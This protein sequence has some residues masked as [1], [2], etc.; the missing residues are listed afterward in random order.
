[1]PAIY[2]CAD[3]GSTKSANK[4]LKNSQPKV[5][6]VKGLINQL[7]TT[8]STSPLGFL[9]TSLIAENQFS[10]SLGKSLPI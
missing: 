1:M 5:A 4:K 8:V 2:S 7:T 10:P 3:A 6:I 9:P